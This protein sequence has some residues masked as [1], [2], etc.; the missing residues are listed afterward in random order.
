MTVFVAKFLRG[1]QAESQDYNNKKK[2][3]NPLNKN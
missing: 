2:R 1:N 3:K